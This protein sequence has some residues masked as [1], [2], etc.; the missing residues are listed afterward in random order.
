[1]PSKDPNDSNYRRLWYVRFADDFLLGLAGS[2]NEAEKIKCDITSFLRNELRLT[3][4]QDKTLI[5]HARGGKAKFLGY[6]IHVLHADDKHDHRSQRCINGSIGLRIP[7]QVKQEKC[8]QYMRHGKPIHL[9]Q[10]TIDT[11]YSIVSQ[12]QVEYRGLVQYYKMAYNLHTLSQLK[13]VM[14]VSL[15]KTLASKQKITCQKV[16]K[17]FSAMVK[18]DEG[19][20][21]KVIQVKVNRPAP[22]LPLTTHFG[23]VSL[24]WNRWSSINDNLTKPIWNKRSE[25]EQRLLAQTCEVCQSQEK[26]E[27]HHVRKLADLQNKCN[28]ELPEWKKRMIARRRKTLVVCHECHKEIQYGRYD[29]EA[30]KR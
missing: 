18:N 25:V 11:A 21:R 19:E 28:T 9:P 29:G 17:Q 16:Y 4:N 13:Y 30:L 2:K 26:I 7:R 10:R 27:V 23:A 15:V 8:A 1:M 14:E 3:L 12:Y 22:K 6:E 5:T 24:K 20:K